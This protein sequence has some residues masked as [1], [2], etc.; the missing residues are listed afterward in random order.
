MT[1]FENLLVSIVIQNFNYERYLP[2]AIES[3]L[4]Q[5]YPRVEVIVVD[6]G[7]TDNSQTIIGGF[8]DRVV[9]LLKENGG[10][11]SAMNAGFAASHGDIVIYLDADDYLF[12]GAVTRIASAYEA[13]IAKVQYRL[14][15]VG[16]DGS[17]LGSEWPRRGA[18]LPSGNLLKRVLEC[19]CYLWP[20]TSGNAFS[21]SALLQVL[22][23][24]ENEYRI[25]AD[26]Y[27][28]PLMP[29]YGNITSIQEPLAAYRIHGANAWAI[30]YQNGEGLGL[31]VDHGTKTHL[32]VASTAQRLGLNISPVFPLR[33]SYYLQVRLESL[34]LAPEKH[35]VSRDNA[36]ALA[37]HGVIALWKWG[38]DLT[39][40]QRLARSAWFVLL[41]I[42]PL[43]PLRA[44]YRK[45]HSR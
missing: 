45:V 22:P 41:A 5:T 38:S 1:K 24:P 16:S 28:N 15:V 27:L 9:P 7:S 31:L 3:A 10:Q 26:A 17:P 13:G 6:D 39:F 32:L 34:R 23:V 21:R 19:G 42:L 11:A 14:Q 33:D 20:P 35:P 43:R 25:A 29:F 44:A 12:D 37:Y 2:Q 40:K 18:L 8:G 30:S 4:N 36:A